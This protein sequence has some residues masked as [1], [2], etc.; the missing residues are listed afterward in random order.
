MRG[1]PKRVPNT[2]KGDY[3]RV[4]V[5]AGS[6]GMTGAAVLASDAAYRSGAGLVTI[7]CPMRSADVISI[8]QTCAIVRPAMNSIAR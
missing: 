7:A 4:L 2:H 6:F 3:G 1:L 8:K 5:V